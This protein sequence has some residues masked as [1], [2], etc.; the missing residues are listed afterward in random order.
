MGRRFHGKHET[1]EKNI[2]ALFHRYLRASGGIH[3][4]RP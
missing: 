1:P 4:T 2:L 3:V